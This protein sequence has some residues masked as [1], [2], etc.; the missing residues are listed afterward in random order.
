MVHEA[1][2]LEILPIR[3][4]LGMHAFYMGWILFWISPVCA[5]LTYL[6]AQFGRSE[7][8]ALSLGTGWLWLVDT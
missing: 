1:H 4:G 5:F 3:L 8:V 7:V 6:G 2:A